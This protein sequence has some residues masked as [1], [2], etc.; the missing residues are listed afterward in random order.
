MKK[1]EFVFI[2]TVKKIS[3]PLFFLLVCLVIN[4][5]IVVISIVLVKNMWEYNFWDI[6]YS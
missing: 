2:F 6:V 4:F 5:T 1:E 3:P